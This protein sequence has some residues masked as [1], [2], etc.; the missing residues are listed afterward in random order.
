MRSP[1]FGARDRGFTL[2]E[3]LVVIAIIGI[4]SSVVLTSLGSA[5]SKAR[6]ARR[7]SDIKSLQTSLELYF[8]T[9]NRYPALEEFAQKPGSPIAGAN[10][11]APDFIPNVSKDPLTDLSYVYAAQSPSSVAGSCQSYHLGAILEDT[12][13]ASPAINGDA[14]LFYGNIACV[15]H[16]SGLTPG[17]IFNGKSDCAIGT[18]TDKCFDITP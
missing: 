14:D 7:I 16:V 10:Y 9:Y 2:I 1:V 3:L 15:P 8:N 17:V 5:R 18:G 13:G 12:T 4:L 11:L 6:D